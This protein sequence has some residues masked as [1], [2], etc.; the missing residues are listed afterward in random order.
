MTNET[1]LSEQTLTDA[2]ENGFRTFQPFI[3]AIWF[4]HYKSLEEGLRIEFLWPIT[5]I[6]GQNGTNKTSILHALAAAPKGRSIAEFWFSTKLDD[7][8]RWDRSAKA[9]LSE[10]R[11]SAE[12]NPHRFVYSYQLQSD[13]VSAECRKARVTRKFRGAGVPESRQGEE[14][15]DYWEPTKVAL[16]DGMK[17]F[18]PDS[19][20]KNKHKDRWALVSKPILF[21][22]MKAEISAF[23]KFLNHS[24]SDRFTD[25]ATKKRIRAQKIADKLE[26]A[27]TGRTKA[28]DIL[29]RVIEGPR[30]LNSQAV[31]DI[32]FILGKD[33]EKVD[34]IKHS[35]FG[36]PGTTFKLHLNTAAIEYSEAHAGSGEFTV[37]RLVD[38]ISRAKKGTLVLLDEPEISLHPGAQER[39][40]QFLFRQALSKKLQVVISTHSPAVVDCLPP[41][42]IKVV[43]FDDTTNQ[44]KL[45][46]QS[47]TPSEAFNSLGFS[48]K[49]NTK[50]T[51]YLEDELSQEMVLATLRRMEDSSADLIETKII[52]G[53]AAGL[54][55][56]VLPV[57]AVQS[58]GRLGNSVILLDGDQK[59]KN[60][61]KFISMSEETLTDLVGQN[62]FDAV[63][64]EYVHETIPK[65]FMHS[66]KSNHEE[67]A[68]LLLKF[69]KERL[70]FIGDTWPEKFLA[71]TESVDGEVDQ[72][73]DNGR[74]WKDWWVS[75]TTD[76]YKLGKKTPADAELVFD[77]QK[78]RLNA[79]EENNDLFKIIAGEI[80]RVTYGLV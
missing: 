68:V 13:S 19:S 72:Y 2:F 16:R 36:A 23:D 32:S 20:H 40:M 63:W 17:E 62:G 41:K 53:G 12:K 15:P 9:E 18:I 34:V 3:T 74:N 28:K 43:G 80:K 39:F 6:V 14:D 67:I 61:D 29:N 33:V 52:P 22:D 37:V 5:A 26:K 65:K 59:R 64:K 56:N 69:A 38:E 46:A 27:L 42:A 11:R 78:F 58:D 7:I 4:P 1:K 24:R 60:F 21:L 31:K 76:H 73:P 51:V 57:L 8:D 71:T 25:N 66:D 77:F 48:L 79:L 45:L 54:I 49:N 44:V 55:Q 47:C 10:S 30:T 50:C 70:G 35:L 75:K